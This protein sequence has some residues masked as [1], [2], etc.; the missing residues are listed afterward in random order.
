L[1]SVWVKNEQL[2]AL[3]HEKGG[4]SL[5]TEKA[6]GRSWEWDTSQ[7][8]EHGRWVLSLTLEDPQNSPHTGSKT[9]FPLRKTGDEENR[10]KSDRKVGSP[11]TRLR[12]G[13]PSISTEGKKKEGG[14]SDRTEGEAT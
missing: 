8:Q 6:I 2:R 14:K 7:G 9:L 10:Q 13:L 3:E 1:K 12:K 5:V 11:V 4:K